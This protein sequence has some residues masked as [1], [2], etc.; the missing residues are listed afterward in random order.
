[1]QDTC[2]DYM[3]LP[4]CKHPIMYIDMETQAATTL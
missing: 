2:Q 1:M 3:V 4:V